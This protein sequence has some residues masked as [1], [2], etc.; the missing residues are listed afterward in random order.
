MSQDMMLANK[1]EIR[2]IIEEILN[3]LVIA[4]G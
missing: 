3:A 2:A 4:A 1:K